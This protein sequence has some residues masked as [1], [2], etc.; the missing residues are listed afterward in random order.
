MKNIDI[1]LERKK[2]G[3]TQ[4]QLADKLGVSLVTVNKW[5]NRRVI[6]RAKYINALKIMSA[7]KIKEVGEAFRPIQYLGSKL[8][9]LE[10]IE[11]LINEHTLGNN[12]CDLFSGSGVVSH[13]LS[14][15]YKIIANDIQRYSCAITEGLL[16]C[17][18]ISDDLL[19]SIMNQL[20]SSN[21]YQKGLKS[22]QKL[23]DFENNSLEE[24]KNGNPNLLIG[25]SEQCSLYTYDVERPL[26]LAKD[27]HFTIIKND[28]L[29]KNKAKEMIITYLYGGVY[30][31]FEQAIYLDVIRQK[32][33]NSLYESSVKNALLAALISTASEIVNTVGKQFAQP[34]KLTDRTGSPKK[35][36]IE[37]TIRDKNYSVLDVFEKFLLKLN[38]ARKHV[39]DK[40]H[41]VY[42]KDSIE[43]LADY[44]DRI[45]CFYVDPPYT[46]DHYSRFYHVLETIAKYDRPVLDV[47]KRK[48]GIKV[49]NG[50]YR[51]DRHQ[52]LFCIPSQVKN[53][54][55]SMIKGC[56]KHQAPL[57]ISYSS[58]DNA[59][60][61]RSRLL[62]TEELKIIA[63]KYYSK[64]E[65]KLASGHVHRKL[66]SNNNNLNV[67]INSEIFIVC[68]GVI[69]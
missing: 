20:R 37:R 63:E 8:R 33:S 47:M 13:Y 28:Y 52:S 62:K 27:D 17:D 41:E 46:I 51:N 55:E 10:N 14:S 65:V 61:E 54:F 29:N 57:I 42:C 31:S 15:N 53:S 40:Q 60:D 4:R 19:K 64:V 56:A 49:M 67:I 3:L 36:Q 58:Y 38:A 50:L 9:L 6:P 12:V 21:L 22:A 68:T 1:V 48:E 32:I 24:A 2:L 34:M 35:L 44:N 59:N 23:I 25:F 39:S 5:E 11:D 43:F 7:E 26:S 18:Q 16:D 45:D 66:H 69:C 30:F